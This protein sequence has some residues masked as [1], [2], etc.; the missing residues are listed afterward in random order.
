MKRIPYLLALLFCLTSC[1]KEEIKQRTQFVKV[2]FANKTFSS[3]SV[4]HE[5]VSNNFSQIPYI[6]SALGENKYEIYNLLTNEKLIDTVLNITGPK[7]YYVYQPFDIVAPV[8][9]SELP[10]KPPVDPRNPLKNEAAAPEGYVKMKISFQTRFILPNQTVDIVVNSFTA[11]SPTVVVPI[12]TLHGVNTDYNTTMFQVKRPVLA[13]G[14]LSQSFTFSLIDPSTGELIK[15]TP[16]NTYSGGN[17]SLP[18]GDKNLF[19]FFFNDV[20]NANRFSAVSVPIDGLY[21]TIR[22]NIVWSI[23]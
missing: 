4:K 21:Y 11:E 19:M 17:I 10:A 20:Q 7:V 23:E 14:T 3:I 6:S 16:G 13:D 8:L 15:N 5:G 1:K 9:I 2:Q 22:S 18:L 12:T